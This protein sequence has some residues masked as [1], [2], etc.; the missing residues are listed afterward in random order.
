MCGN[1]IDF[2]R[3]QTSG[4]V[5]RHGAIDVI[6]DR[7]RV[8]PVTSNRL[9]GFLRVEAALTAYQHIVGTFGPGFSMAGGAIRRV[10]LAA[11]YCRP[12]APRQLLDRL[13]AHRWDLR[14]RFFHGR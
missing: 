4:L 8:G 9:N 5:V 6:P 10:D 14:S 3:A 11:L 2:V 13:P 12:A 7:R 1:G